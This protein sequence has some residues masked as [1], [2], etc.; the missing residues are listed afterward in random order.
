MHEC[1][2]QTAISQ[3]FR[4]TIR[5]HPAFESCRPHLR[6]EVSFI[7]WTNCLAWTLISDV[8]ITSLE[9]SGTQKL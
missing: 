8:I 5:E 9:M 4:G 1:M 3:I 6:K 2:F 7:V